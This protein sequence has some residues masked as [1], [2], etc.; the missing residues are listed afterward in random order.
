[1]ERTLYS[2]DYK[3]K[4]FESLTLGKH[5]KD[6]LRVG[7]WKHPTKKQAVE[8]T[9][10]RIKDLCENTTAWIKNGGNDVFFP[11]RHRWDPEKNLGFWNNFE[12]SKDGS[13]LFALV[14]VPNED[15]SAKIGKEIKRVSPCIEFNVSDSH[16]TK[17]PEVI[18]HICATL[19]P[20][21]P[22]QD[23]FEPVA[24]AADRLCF[25]VNDE[26]YNLLLLENEGEQTMVVEKKDEP[27]EEKKPETPEEKKEPE[28]PEAPA[29]EKPPE[30]ETPPEK[31]EPEEEEKEPET[32]S[33][34]MLLMEKQVHDQAKTILSLSLEKV[35]KEVHEA[36]ALGKITSAER[37]D[38]MNLL[39]AEAS[40]ASEV[41]ILSR[42]DKGNTKKIK[43]DVSSI[44]RNLLQGKE[45]N[46]TVDMRKLSV[47]RFYTGD[48]EELARREEKCEMYEAEAKRHEQQ[49]RKVVWNDDKDHSKNFETQVGNS[50]SS[51]Q[52][53]LEK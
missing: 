25:S 42:D 30:E 38:W 24:Q 5:R 37:K 15:M 12:I 36:I 18:T 9:P 46:T 11:S 10:Q 32:M 49:G 40:G 23:N 19:E 31:M 34:R 39:L 7:K 47:D 20:V 13:T 17:Y 45:P 26:K 48:R 52:E 3:G 43:V 33:R 2:L 4:N 21:I 53:T 51:S 28:T 50:V 1:M 8:F 41:E 14:D 6:V 27:A 35:E 22:G 16:G 44:A 29:E